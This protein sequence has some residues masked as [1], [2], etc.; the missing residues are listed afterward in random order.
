MLPA[1]MPLPKRPYV[2][3]PDEIRITRDG[4]YAVIEYAEPKVA[5]ASLMEVKWR[6]IKML[7]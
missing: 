2:A 3:S 5:T 1:T 4:D 7:G 6:A